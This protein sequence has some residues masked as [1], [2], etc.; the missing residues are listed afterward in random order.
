MSRSINWLQVGAA[1]LLGL[2]GVFV[3][4]H[5]SDYPLG[6]LRRMGPGFYPVMVGSVLLLFSVLLV[7]E[8]AHSEKEKD[9]WIPRPV[10]TIGAGF[11]AFA[12]LLE[13]AGLV[14]ATLAMV[15]LV[16]L[17]EK[18]TRPVAI[19]ATAVGLSVL[20]VVVFLYGFGI[21]VPAIQW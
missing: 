15:I 2:I 3:I 10:L 20:G 5:G 16:S 9:F 4:W 11:I 18:P 6:S 12:A 14:P 21:P 19:I 8:V 1:V 13:R 17:A 7:L